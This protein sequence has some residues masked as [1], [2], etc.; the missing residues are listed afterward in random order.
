M[1]KFI[2]NIM[3]ISRERNKIDSSPLPV[4]P[5]AFSFS[6]DNGV[7]IDTFLN[8]TPSQ[9]PVLFPTPSFTIGEINNYLYY[10]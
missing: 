6:L 2:I 5:V 3:I 4:L 1:E 9:I 7:D 8:L 10:I